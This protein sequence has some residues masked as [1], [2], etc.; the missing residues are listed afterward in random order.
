MV[1][2]TNNVWHLIDDQQHHSNM[3]TRLQYGSSREFPILEARY[4]YG[5]FPILGPIWE[6]FPILELSFTPL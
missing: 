1:I 6:E 5:M 4:Q 2:S 3:G